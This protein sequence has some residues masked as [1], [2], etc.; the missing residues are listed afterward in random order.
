MPVGCLRW[1]FHR[2]K[3]FEINGAAEMS[4]KASVAGLYDKA[5]QIST[6]EDVEMITVFF[7]PYAAQMVMG[8]PCKE[9]TYD[10]VEFEGLENIEFIDLKNRVLEAATTDDCIRMIEEFILKQLVKTQDS[11][12]LEPLI[13]VFKTMESN[14]EARVED[15]ANAACLSERQ[16]RRIFTDNVGMKPK[17]IQRIQRFHLATNEILQ[18]RAENLDDILYK[19]GYTD[20]SHFNHEFHDIV[21]ISPSEYLT[22]LEG[23]RKHGIMPIYRSYHAPE[24]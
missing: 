20:H 22:F 6:S 17:Q 18:S 9:F 23:V 16:F 13:K 12:Y 14:P 21:G 11:P 3:P 2:K 8:I 10:N 24:K 4:R 1:M 5:I 7:L 19:F 15:L